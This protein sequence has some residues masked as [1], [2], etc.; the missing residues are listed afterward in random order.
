MNK[1]D[2][3]IRIQAGSINELW[4]RIKDLEESIMNITSFEK[5]K[6]NT[7]L[8]NSNKMPIAKIVVIENK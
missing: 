8:E 7:T 5:L 3:L 2:I 6:E 1:K 4:S